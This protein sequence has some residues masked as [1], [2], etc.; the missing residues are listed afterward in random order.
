MTREL[1]PCGTPAAYRRHLRHGEYP[2][3]ACREAELERNRKHGPFRP[4]VCGTPSG[5]NRHLKRREQACDACRKAHNTAVVERRWRN[6]S[7]PDIP[8]GHSGYVNWN[9]RCEVCRTAK[10]EAHRAYWARR[11]LR[12]AAS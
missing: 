12:E 8:H 9:C 5:Y 4:A 11:R 3:E 7:R 10:N 2:C 6:A 1:K